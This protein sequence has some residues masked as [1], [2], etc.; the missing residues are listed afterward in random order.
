[1]GEYLKVAQVK[2]IYVKCVLVNNT[3]SLTHEVKCPQYEGIDIVNTYETF[4]KRMD[5]N[6]SDVQLLLR[7]RQQ[8]DS[9][10]EH[11]KQHFKSN[12]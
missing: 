6:L 3:S 8:S 1:M 11:I 2:K 5:G 7:K 4:K 12:T 9:F 10:A